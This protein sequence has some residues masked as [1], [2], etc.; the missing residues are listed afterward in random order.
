ME[1][2]GLIFHCIVLCFKVKGNIHKHVLHL[3]DFLC[4]LSVQNHP[5]PTKPDQQSISGRF[6]L[7]ETDTS[8]HRIRRSCSLKPWAKLRTEIKL[9]V[10][11]FHYPT[12]TSIRFPSGP[13]PGLCQAL[14]PI[15]SPLSV[16]L[17][18]CKVLFGS[19]LSKN[20]PPRGCPSVTGTIK[21]FFLHPCSPPPFFI[22][23]SKHIS[24]MSCLL[25]CSWQWAEWVQVGAPRRP[26]HKPP[27]VH[28]HT[29]LK[30]TWENCKP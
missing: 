7:Y 12:H 1:F 13:F 9:T 29:K 27:A 5:K 25:H 14:M 20:S 6:Q 19:L 24:K 15:L 30:D 8:R 11:Q 28:L 23:I 4:Q 2:P 26:T 17:V 16:T 21:S 3:T 22:F 10:L 18:N